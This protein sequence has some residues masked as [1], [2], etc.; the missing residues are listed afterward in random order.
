MEPTLLIELRFKGRKRDIYED[1][2]IET[3]NLYFEHPKIV[4]KLKIRI[5]EIIKNGRTIR[6][7]SQD[8]VR[9][10]WEQLT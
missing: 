6:G 10:N 3:T 4:K 7:I 5:T 9:S 1:D 2:P 8:Y